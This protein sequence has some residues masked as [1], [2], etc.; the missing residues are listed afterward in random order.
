M[1]GPPIYLQAN[2]SNPG[3]VKGYDHGRQFDFNVEDE[4]PAQIRALHDKLTKTMPR[5]AVTGQKVKA[6]SYKLAPVHDAN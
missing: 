6:G 5:N 2:P 1:A 4:N 3:G